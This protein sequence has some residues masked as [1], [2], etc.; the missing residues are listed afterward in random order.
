MS[1]TDPRSRLGDELARYT[2]RTWRVP[3][4]RGLLMLVVGWRS[5]SPR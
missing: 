1:W 3:L 5:C 2:A 4:V